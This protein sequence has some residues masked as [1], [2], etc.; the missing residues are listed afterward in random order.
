[1]CR[2]GVSAKFARV[3]F[4]FWDDFFGDI[5]YKVEQKCSK[6]CARLPLTS[7]P[8][9]SNES[10]KN[11]SSNSLS[12]SQTKPRLSRGLCRRP[13]SIVQRFLNPLLRKFMPDSA[14]L[15][16]SWATFAESSRQTPR[17]WKRYSGSLMP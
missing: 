6:S 8:R 13:R 15:K 2:N 9:A 11:P 10:K 4:L 16:M 12:Q 1:M 3:L 7:T 14:S 5:F 17:N